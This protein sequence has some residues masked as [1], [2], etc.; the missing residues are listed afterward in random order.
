[1]YIQDHR[2]APDSIPN[3]PRP[4]GRVR[5]PN[6]YGGVLVVMPYQ[7]YLWI[8]PELKQVAGYRGDLI[9]PAFPVLPKARRVA[10]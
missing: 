4:L 1:M 8:N 5:T 10:A 3:Q 7:H 2:I 6:E 9:F